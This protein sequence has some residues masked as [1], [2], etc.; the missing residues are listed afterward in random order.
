MKDLNSRC[1]ILATRNKHKIIE[2][3]NVLSDLKLE[4]LTLD[5]FPE[6]PEVIEDGETIEENAQKKARSVYAATGILC[7]ADDTGL[8]VDFLKGKPGVF[9]SRYASPTATYEMNNTKLLHDLSGVPYE[10]RTAKFRC[11]MAVVD[12]GKLKLLEGVC[13]GY[14]LVEIRGTQGFGYDPLF[15]VPQYRKTFAEL[16]LEEKNKISH[17][18]QALQQVRNYL[19]NLLDF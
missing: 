10:K 7:L 16:S 11:V 3:K 15:Y 18:G 19:K 4:I 2:I 5:C 12:N 6:I 9:S 8:E 1:I 14:I 17:R 13:Q